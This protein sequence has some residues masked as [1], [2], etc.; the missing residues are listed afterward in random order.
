VI[1]SQQIKNLFE[2]DQGNDRVEGIYLTIVRLSVSLEENQRQT[3]WKT[4]FLWRHQPILHQY[5][6]ITSKSEMI[7]GWLDSFL[8]W[9]NRALGTG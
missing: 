2:F 7:K 3:G 8:S 1:G 6:T 9:I 4:G 5:G